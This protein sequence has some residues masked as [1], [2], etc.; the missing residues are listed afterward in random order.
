M[1]STR[2]KNTC[3]DYCLQQK[4]NSGTLDYTQYT[5]GQYGY[6]YKPALPCF[7]FNPSHMPR[8]ILSKNSIDIES[9]LFGINST[10]LVDPQ[11]P[12]DPILTKLPE[13]SYFGR[14]PLL[15]PD[16]LVIQ[17]NRPF[18]VPQ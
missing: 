17:P 6:A 4:V 16:P 13:I 10:N 18:P 11:K 15:M 3:S 5:N 12:V 8:E 1:T 14:L 7:G 9:A 2:N